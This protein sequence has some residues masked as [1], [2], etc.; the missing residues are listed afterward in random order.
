M[1]ITIGVLVTQDDD[2]EVVVCEDCRGRSKDED[3]V[4]RWSWPWSSA[5]IASSSVWSFLMII[6]FLFVVDVVDDVVVVVV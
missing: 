3:E 2:D 6:S 1:L 5:S 4:R